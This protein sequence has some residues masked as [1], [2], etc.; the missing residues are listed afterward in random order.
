MRQNL[1]AYK[2]VDVES[3]LLAADPHQVILMMFGGILDSL[4]QAKGAIERKN[5]E[6]KST[7]MSKSISLINALDGALDHE[8]QPEISG[9]FSNLYNY[10][11]NRLME[12][13]ATLDVSVIDEVINLLKPI[14]DA[15]QEM[16]EDSKRKGFDLLS[17]KATDS[18]AV[19][20]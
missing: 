7:L 4:S 12:A 8:S 9:N 10:C 6:Q 2:K 19:G 14:K 13:S 15:W 5:F 16:P 18:Q 20:A 17:Q 11:V 1:K 3:S